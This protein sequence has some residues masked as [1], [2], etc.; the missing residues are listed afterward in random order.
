MAWAQNF[1]WI[2]FEQQRSH[3]LLI[4]S[5]KWVYLIKFVNFGSTCN[6]ICKKVRK[7]TTVSRACQLLLPA[8]YM[9]SSKAHSK[10]FIKKRFNIKVRSCYCTNSRLSF[11]RNFQ[12]RYFHRWN[13]CDINF[14]DFR[15]NLFGGTSKSPHSQKYI[16]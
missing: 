2:L 10:Y 12:M 14:R 8:L 15:E 16:H 11:K 9:K 5:H 13:F 6:H 3:V 7:Y 4:T 1:C